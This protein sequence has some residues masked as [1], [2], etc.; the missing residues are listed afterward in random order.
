M[1]AVDY[2]FCHSRSIDG[3][4]FRHSANSAV[5]LIVSE[6]STVKL[7]LAMEGPDTF[8]NGMDI[9]PKMGI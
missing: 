5:G 3:A 1:S 9:L 8:L 4:A 6:S 7:R 2:G